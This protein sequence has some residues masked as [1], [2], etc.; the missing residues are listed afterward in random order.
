M[1][2]G[3]LFNLRDVVE[4]RVELHYMQQP[5]GHV[6]RSFGIVICVDATPFWKA[7]AT[8]GDVYIDLADSTRS[9]GRPSL[10]SRGFTFDGSHDADPLRLADKLGQLDAQE[11]ELQR[12]G[13]S[14]PTVTVEV[15]CFLTGDDKG[16]YAGHTK[17][18]CR[19]WHCDPAFADFR[20]DNLRPSDFIISIRW[21]AF[22]RS[23]P[24]TRRVG[25]M[26]HCCCRIV[27]AIFK[28]LWSDGRISQARALGPLL[29]NVVQTV[30]QAAAHI[31]S[32]IMDAA[33]PTKD[34]NFD[35]SGGG[36]ALP[37]I[38]RTTQKLCSLFNSMRD[39]KS[40]WL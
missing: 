35:L 7:S 27:N 32:E 34:G 33:R 6:P 3:A 30:M 2:D 22:L 21:G 31:P 38:S 15:E 39:L 8:R 37:E 9:A 24:P 20:G 4:Q 1:W 29:R 18:K 40:V 16:M 11:G 23:M 10:W 5:Q 13:I 12:N 28:R 19:C 36:G 14:T 26:V 17:L 25:D